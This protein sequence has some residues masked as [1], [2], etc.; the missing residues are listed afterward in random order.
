MKTNGLLKAASITL[1]SGLLACATARTSPQLV[2]AAEA[3]DNASKGPA[4]ELNPADLHD[5]QVL[6]TAAEEAARQDPDS[7]TAHTKA[8]LAERRAQLADAQGRTSAATRDRDRATKELAALKDAALV[9]AKGQLVEAGEDQQRAEA[10]LSQAQA[11]LG[12]E[13]REKRTT[14]EF[15]AMERERQG[16]K[17]QA[18]K[19][20]VDQA[21]A[22]VGQAKAEVDQAKAEVDQAKA[23]V[24]QANAGEQQAKAE[25]SQ[26]EAQL[27]AEQKARA[28]SDPRAQE[29]FEALA[30]V[31]AVRR[32]PRG[33][34]ITLSGSVVFA[35][36]K[37]VLLI[38]AQRRLDQVAV[39][40]KDHDGPVLIEGHTDSL[41]PTAFNQSLSESR[42]SAVLEYLVSR[43]FARERLRS[44]GLGSSRALVDNASAEG[45][46]HNRRVEI[47]LEPKQTPVN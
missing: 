22:E 27:D 36:G 41:G 35:S 5:A 2:R 40:L 24:D 37:S 38:A 8:Y 9:K 6:L 16:V 13:R 1:L 30:K 21:K 29:S 12:V 44:V 33:T 28:A 18:S 19:A 39:S 10:K 32:E 15:A 26:K 11:Q 34:V 4:A 46:A 31:A 20:E 42:A 3:Y 14:A 17:D 7:P 47:V 25:L 23:E 45:R 43:G